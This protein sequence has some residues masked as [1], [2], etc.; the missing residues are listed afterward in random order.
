MSQKALFEG[1]VAAPDGQPVEAAR[2][3]GVAQYVVF[4][5]GFKFHVDAEAVDREV[6]RLLGEQ[7]SAH[8]EAVAEGAM[9][10][11]GQDDLFTKAI[12]DSSLSNLD[13]NFDR[14]IEQGLPENA[15]AYLGMLGFRVVINYH[16]EVVRL[17]QPGIAAADDEGE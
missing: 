6:L 2:V 4:D 7:I 17:E 13:A 1:L 14:L 16:G 15:R 9:K 11:I 8:K 10:M 3:G 12:I 5:G